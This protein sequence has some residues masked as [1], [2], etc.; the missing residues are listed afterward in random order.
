MKAAVT[1]INLQINAL[2][3]IQDTAGTVQGKVAT[4]KGFQ[5]VECTL[6]PKLLGF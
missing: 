4:E 6:E 3:Y 5:E 1:I 2:Q